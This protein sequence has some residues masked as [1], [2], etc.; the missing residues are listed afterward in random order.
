MQSQLAFLSASK[1]PQKRPG[2][3]FGNCS[4]KNEK[5]YVEHLVKTAEEHT[6]AVAIVQASKVNSDTCSCSVLRKYKIIL[7]DA[8]Y[9]MKKAKSE[10]LTT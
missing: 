6:Y 1:K 8:F 3:D 4:I 9:S 7:N 10:Y 2:K 5:R